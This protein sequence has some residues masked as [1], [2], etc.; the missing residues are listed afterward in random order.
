MTDGLLLIHAF[1]LD[2]RM[3]S[4]QMDRRNVVAPD[5][6]GFGGSPA[7]DGGEPEEV[8]RAILWLLSED[9]SYCTGAFIDVSGGR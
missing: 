9:A 2:A 1:P 7:A 4:A 6:P 3:W 8:A 5:L